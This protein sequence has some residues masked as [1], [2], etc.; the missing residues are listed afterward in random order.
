MRVCVRACVCGFAT[1]F[2]QLTRTTAGVFGTSLVTVV[3]ELTD[4]V[5]V[6]RTSLLQL[7][8]SLLRAV[9]AQVSVGI[10]IFVVVV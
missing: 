4:K 5:A 1:P 2:S 8:Q 3:T 7:V 6:V 9:T 10:F